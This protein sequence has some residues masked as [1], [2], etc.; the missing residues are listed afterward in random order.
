MNPPACPNSNHGSPLERFAQFFTNWSGSSWAFTVALLTILVW[1]VTGPFFHFF[2][3]L[4]TR[5]PTQN[6]HRYVLDGVPHSTLAE[7]GS[8][9]VQLKA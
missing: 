1:A 3:H 8:A 5:H 9:A 6:D 7:Q 2:R 4:A